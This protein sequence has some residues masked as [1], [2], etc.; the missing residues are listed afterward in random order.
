MFPTM[1]R[2]L[3]QPEIFLAPLRW[4][5]KVRLGPVGTADEPARFDD[6]S[7]YYSRTVSPVGNLQRMTVFRRELPLSVHASQAAEASCRKGTTRAL[8]SWLSSS[9]DPTVPSV[10]PLTASLF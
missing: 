4:E 8:L 3:A 6:E 10:F 9:A 5:E 1:E 7:L 2:L